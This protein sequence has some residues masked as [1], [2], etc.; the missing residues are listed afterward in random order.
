[1]WLVGAPVHLSQQRS[2]IEHGLG[3]IKRELGRRSWM[4]KLNYPR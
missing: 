3:C 2:V 4:S 1:M